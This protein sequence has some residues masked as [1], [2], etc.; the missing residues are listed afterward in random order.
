[1]ASDIL[2]EGTKVRIVNYE[3][4]PE[5]NGQ[6]AEIGKHDE[7]D[8][9]YECWLIA[10][11]HEG[12]YAFCTLDQLE[13]VLAFGVGDRVRGKESGE[14]GT[15]TAVDSDGDPKVK[16]DGDSEPQQR[17]AK[18]FD[19]VEKAI[20][21]VG[22][23]VKGKESGQI[24]TVTAVDADG[25][26]K[27]IVD[28]EAEA[29]QRFAKAFEIVWK[30][31]FEIGDRVR[32]K[33]SGKTGTVT[34]VDSDGDPVVKLDE[35][36]EPQQRFAHA[37][38]IIEKKPKDTDEKSEGKKKKKK[39]RDSSSSSSSSSDK[40]KKKKKKKKKNSSSDK[41]SA[42]ARAKKNRTAFGGRSTLERIEDERRKAKKLKKEGN[43][44][45]SAALNL[46]GSSQL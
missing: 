11:E 2:S 21:S 19:I 5:F 42:S 4:R 45:M 40:K 9:K 29:S 8:N 3:Q 24:G 28:G 34:A 7:K 37:F 25:D 6:E 38:R 12:S 20:F 26:P 10:D 32:G 15:V 22:D 33:D 36:D 14:M 18:A 27:V 43:V 39:K 17:F 30:A 13:I 1:M 46:L 41:S 44:G 16:M 23:R 31:P 35:E